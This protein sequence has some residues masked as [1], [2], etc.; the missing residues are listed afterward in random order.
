MNAIARQT[1][2]T[3]KGKRPTP[4]VPAMLLLGGLLIGSHVAGCKSSCKPIPCPPAYQV[5]PDSC[6]CVSQGNAAS[7]ERD[8]GLSCHGPV[9]CSDASPDPYCDWAISR[10]SSTW[11]A[12]GPSPGISTRECDD[13][14]TAL[15]FRGSDSAVTYFYRVGLLMAVIDEIGSGTQTGVQTCEQGPQ[16]FQVPKCGEYTLVCPNGIDASSDGASDVGSE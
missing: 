9:T 6:E 2:K 13:G 12:R 8:A 3:R 4:A 10:N 16:A 7:P 14:T 15:T 11:C 1:I 5:D